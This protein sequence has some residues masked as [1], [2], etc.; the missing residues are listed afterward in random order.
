MTAVAPE[1]TGRKTAGGGFLP[2]RAVWERYGVTAMSLHRWQRNEDLHFPKPIYLGRFRYW[3][4]ADLTEWEA[5][6]P[7]SP[8]KSE[9]A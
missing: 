7:R 4:L 6:R 1:V 9:A 5:S 8:A 3:K 2:A